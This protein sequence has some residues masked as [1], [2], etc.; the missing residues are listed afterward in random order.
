MTWAIAR[1]VSLIIPH[2]SGRFFSNSSKVKEYVTNIGYVCNGNSQSNTTIY[3][4][5]N[6]VVLDWDLET[7]SRVLFYLY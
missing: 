3:W 7:N 6:N 5:K 2:Q 4:I 1:W